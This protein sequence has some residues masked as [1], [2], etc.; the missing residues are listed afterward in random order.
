MDADDDLDVADVDLLTN[1]I[2]QGM[3]VPMFNLKNADQAVD[4]EDLRVWVKDLKQTGYGDANV[5]GEFNTDDFVT[6]FQ[7]GQYEDEVS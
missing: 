4:T 1:A 2:W 6:I 3:D 5:D 7:A